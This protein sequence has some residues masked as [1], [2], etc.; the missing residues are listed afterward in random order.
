VDEQGTSLD[1]SHTP[2][3]S[4]QAPPLPGGRAVAGTGFGVSQQP[5]IEKACRLPDALEASGEVL[6]S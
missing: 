2:E 1:S 6:K 5:S 3:A 4:E